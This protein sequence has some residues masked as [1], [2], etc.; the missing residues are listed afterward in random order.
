MLIKVC[1]N[2]AVNL[3]PLLEKINITYYDASYY[4]EDDNWD[5]IHA[6]EFDINDLITSL[7][8]IIRIN[9]L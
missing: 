9:G 1:G 4:E 5:K 2:D 8:L 7:D 6:I 3:K